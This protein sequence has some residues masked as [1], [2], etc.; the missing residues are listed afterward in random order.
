MENMDCLLGQ[1]FVW[2]RGQLCED[3]EGLIS[4]VVSK[5]SCPMEASS[6]VVCALVWVHGLCLCLVLG[7]SEVREVLQVL[8]VLGGGVW[9][10]K[11]GSWC[12]EGCK[13]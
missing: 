1:S 13:G 5:V 7:P 12:L 2:A 8:E 11:Q 6:L 10:E 9:R 3:L 4:L